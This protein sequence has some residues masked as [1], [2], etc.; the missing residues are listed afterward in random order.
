MILSSRNQ[1]TP[2]ERFR[3][4]LQQFALN[5]MF[6]PVSAAE[7]LLKGFCMGFGACNVAVVG[8]PPTNDGTRFDIAIQLSQGGP[9]V[10]VHLFL[11]TAPVFKEEVNV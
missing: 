9:F 2:V 5:L 6:E 1:P 8:Y 11:A 7:Y 3:T 4:A 10:Y